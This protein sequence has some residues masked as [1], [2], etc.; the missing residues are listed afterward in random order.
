MNVLDNNVIGLKAGYDYTQL[1]EDSG[2]VK[3]NTEVTDKSVII[4]MG[5]NSITHIDTYVD[6]SVY[7]KK[8]QV[9]L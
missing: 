2:L 1:D 8:G 6:N 9:V 3:E 7:A 4:G 5:T